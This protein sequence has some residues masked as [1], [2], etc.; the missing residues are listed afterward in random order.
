MKNW[1]WMREWSRVCW[2]LGSKTC[3]KT[4]EVLKTSGFEWVFE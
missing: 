1:R 4:E 2:W 3:L